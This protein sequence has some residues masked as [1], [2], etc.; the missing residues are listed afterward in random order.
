MSYLLPQRPQNGS[1]DGQLTLYGKISLDSS[2]LKHF[3]KP[4]FSYML[5]IAT[6][7][8]IARISHLKN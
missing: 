6:R 8:V 4:N 5:L 2:E 3:F 7:E 1:D